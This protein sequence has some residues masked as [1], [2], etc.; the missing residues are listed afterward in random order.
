MNGAEHHRCQHE[1]LEHTDDPLFPAAVLALKQVDD[2]GFRV[3][4]IG[5]QRGER[6]EN[7]GH[8]HK[9]AAKAMENGIYGRLGIGHVIVPKLR[10]AGIQHAALAVQDVV[11][12]RGKD[13]ERRSR[14]HQ[15]GIHIHG[16]RLCQALLGRMLYVRCG[17]Y[18]GP[19]A[20]PGLIG[21]NTAL[22]AH[23][24][25]GTQDTAA[26]G[27]EAECPFENGAENGRHLMDMH[28]HHHQ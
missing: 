16:K 4:V 11:G 8:R 15:Q 6:E 5:Q 20:L 24:D 27:T 10:G 19:S 12:A 25:G 2:A 17:R 23:G 28:T 26:N 21:E 13:H 18:D 7:H 1:K 14:A 9:A 22:D 3:K